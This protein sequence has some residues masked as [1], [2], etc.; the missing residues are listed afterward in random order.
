MSGHGTIDA[1][2]RATRL[3][4]LQFLEKPI[5]TDALL[6]TVETALRLD[7]AEAEAKALRAASGSSGDLVGESPEIKLSSTELVDARGEEQRR[8]A[9]S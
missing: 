5:N 7:R 9:S 4:A 8:D 1:A 2:V 6:I 3:G